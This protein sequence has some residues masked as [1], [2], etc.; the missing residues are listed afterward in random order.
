[1][2]SLK[3]KSQKLTF[4]LPNY[5][6]RYL[7]G[8]NSSGTYIDESL[9]NITGTVEQGLGYSVAWNA[10]LND[11][12]GALYGIHATTKCADAAGVS[13]A[14]SKGFG[15][16]ASRSSNVYKDNAKVRPDSLSAMYCIKY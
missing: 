3:C 12:G 9:P 14:Y 5:I 1:M 16:D 6:N 13:G 11:N 10:A 7:M 4:N 15:I 8:S 2:Q